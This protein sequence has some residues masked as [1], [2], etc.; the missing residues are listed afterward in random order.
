MRPPRRT[1]PTVVLLERA[2][3]SRGRVL[4]TI[5]G[6][7]KV[8]ARW[9]SV[10]PASVDAHPRGGPEPALALHKIDQAAAHYRIVLMTSPLGTEAE[11]AALGKPPW[12]T[13][14]ISLAHV[15]SRIVW[16]RCFPSSAAALQLQGFSALA[17]GRSRCGGARLLT[18]ALALPVIAPQKGDEGRA[19][20]E[21]AA[22]AGARRRES[23]RVTPQNRW[24]RHKKSSRREDTPA[25]R[26]DYALLLMTAERESAANTA[27]GKF[28][29][30]NPEYAPVALRFAGTRRISRGA[31]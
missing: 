10:D 20:R 22:H 4:A 6:R 24:R 30:E 26:L 5:V 15:S 19:A 18:A 31:S 29:R 11:F 16:R 17:R 1:K 25:N 7:K 8:A 9:I 3:Q 28:W 23:W 14:T 12:P 21:F 2:T 13:T 27:I